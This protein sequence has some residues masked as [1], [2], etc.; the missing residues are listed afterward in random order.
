[1]SDREY[2]V[3][4][5]DSAPG[6]GETI[7]PTTNRQEAE[8]QVR[9]YAQLNATRGTYGIAASVVYRYRFMPDMPWEDA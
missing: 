4:V 5:F 1:M 9:H 6:A 2:A 7:R 8:A 3:R